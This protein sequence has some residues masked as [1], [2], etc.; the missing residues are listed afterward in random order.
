M[1]VCF[2]YNPSLPLRLRRD[3]SDTGGGGA[4]DCSGVDDDLETDASDDNTCGWQPVG[5]HYNTNGNIKSANT[6]K[7][8]TATGAASDP[9]Q[10]LLSQHESNARHHP[11]TPLTAA[12][13]PSLPPSAAANCYMN[14]DAQTCG[15]PLCNR[16]MVTLQGDV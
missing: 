10:A 2:L 9:G 4:A 15:E 8:G 12:L 3:K 11:T 16:M 5:D 6:Y 14:A 7:V 1:F 13:S